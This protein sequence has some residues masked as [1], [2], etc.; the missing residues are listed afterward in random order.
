MNKESG[1]HAIGGGYN[2]D[3]HGL[4]FPSCGQ[5]VESPSSSPACT[6]RQISSGDGVTRYS[7]YHSIVPRASCA[8]ATPAKLRLHRSYP[9]RSWP[10]RQRFDETPDSRFARASRA[11]HPVSHV[12]PRGGMA[13]STKPIRTCLG[14][15]GS[16]CE[17]PAIV[18]LSLLA[19]GSLLVWSLWAS[20]TA[21][22][23]SFALSI[24]FGMV[25]SIQ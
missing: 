18:S 19:C 24:A 1:V 21:W 16:G 9:S 2:P 14:E 20:R 4:G 11:V 22:N 12:G 25:L 10:R 6:T 8:E 23:F 15:G 5:S 13:C 17:Q 7:G 3:L